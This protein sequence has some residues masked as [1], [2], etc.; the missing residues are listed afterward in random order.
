MAILIAAPA[1]IERGR[2]QA[3]DE[4]LQ[5]ATRTQLAYTNNR[6]AYE[7]MC[8]NIYE[9]LRLLKAAEAEGS[10]DATHNLKIFVDSKKQR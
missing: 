7:L 6:G 4:F 9:G 2:L 10:A 8:N 5:L 1:A 3:A